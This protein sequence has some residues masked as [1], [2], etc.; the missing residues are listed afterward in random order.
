MNYKQA[1]EKMEQIAKKGSVLGLEPV[2]ILCERLGNPQDKINVIHIAG[3]NGKGSILA[4]LESIFIEGGYKVGKYSSP[5]LFSYLER[6]KINGENME[7]EE[8][9]S[10][11]TKIDKCLNEMKK[12]NAPMPTAFEVETAIAFD[13]FYEKGVDVVLLE[14]GMGGA[15]DATNIVKHPVCTV[16]AS[17][18]MDHMVFL[19]NTLS[20]IAEKKA[21]I[22]KESVPVVVSP[23]Q[24]KEAIGVLIETA[25]RKHAP[26]FQAQMP[27]I[28]DF[29]LEK[30]SFY[31][32]EKEGKKYEI[33]L[34]GT[35]QP[36]N[37]AT[38]LKVV[39]VL[40][41]NFPFTELQIA[42]GLKNTKW[43]ARFEMIEKE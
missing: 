29:S 3:T 41:E 8:F 22:I 43:P 31:F 20:K 17:V 9:A 40:K 36:E 4:Y 38:A 24:K 34:L 18:D 33:A 23:N 2:S 1:M 32:P 37:A 7:E 13:F 39:E 25:E 16:I 19:G 28:Y 15:L 10:Y 30:Q 35:H 12:T 21:G 42:E 14:T 27:E 26:F 5:T 6:F 11:F